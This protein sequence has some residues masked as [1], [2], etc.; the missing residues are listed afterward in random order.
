MFCNKKAKIEKD[1]QMKFYIRLSILDKAG[2]LA[3]IAKTLGDNKISIESAIQDKNDNPEVKSLIIVTHSTSSLN[4]QKAL[5]K[6]AKAE[7]VQSVD[8]VL[9]VLG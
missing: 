9:E 1:G 5:D 4:M 6:I 8:S 3:I 2:V 7:V